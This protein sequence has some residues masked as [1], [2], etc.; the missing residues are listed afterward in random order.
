MADPCAIVKE[1]INVQLQ[2][3]FPGPSYRVLAGLVVHQSCADRNDPA[4]RDAFC[5]GKA[6]WIGTAFNAS[7]LFGSALHSYVWLDKEAVDAGTSAV[8]IYEDEVSGKMVVDTVLKSSGLFWPVCMAN[9]GV[10]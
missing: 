1:S 10:V 6:T 2:F 9:C 8:V 3:L 4:G 7:F 5:N